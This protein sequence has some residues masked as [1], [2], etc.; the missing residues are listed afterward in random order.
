MDLEHMVVILT[1]CSFKATAVRKLILGRIVVK[2]S[3]F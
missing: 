3:T 2:I 1:C